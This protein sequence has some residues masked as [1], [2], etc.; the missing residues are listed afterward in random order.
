M[1]KTVLEYLNGKANDV[2]DYIVAKA[3]AAGNYLSDQATDIKNGLVKGTATVLTAAMLLGGMTAC[4]T[5]TPVENP[6]N[7]PGTTITDPNNQGSQPNNQTTLRPREEIEQ[8]GITAEDVLAAIDNLVKQYYYL[9]KKQY[10]TEENA[11]ILDEIDYKFESIT[12]KHSFVPSEENPEDLYA[13][14]DPMFI[15]QD[16]LEIYYNWFSK[17][18]NLEDVY[19]IHF[20]F[21]TTYTNEGVP[22]QHNTTVKNFVISQSDLNNILNAFN[23]EKFIITQDYINSLGIA[24]SSYRDLIGQ[25]LYKNTTINRQML[26]SAT[27]EQLWALYDAITNSMTQININGETQLDNSNEMQP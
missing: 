2:K 23:V 24:G 25:E 3:E 20:N 17:E 14:I 13:M 5:N 16:S 4:D 19:Q 27:P 12:P 10:I 7:T 6:D 15:P 8:T 11:H 18:M 9:S 26:E 1:N 21:S 22:E